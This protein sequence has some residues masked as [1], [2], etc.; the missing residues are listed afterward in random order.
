MSN[1]D[2]KALTRSNRRL[3]GICAGVVVGMF[4]FGYALVPLY[5]VFCEITGL[6]GKT[7]VVAEASVPA[8]EVD[9]SR[10]VTV[11][12]TG[13]TMAG[14]P[15]EFRPVTRRMTVHPGAIMETSYIA[16]NPAGIAVAGQAVPS[17]APSVAA[18]HFNKTECFC[19]TRQVLQPGEERD[20]PVRFVV[21]PR[22]PQ[23][24]TTVTLSYSFFYTDDQG[25]PEDLSGQD[26][27]AEPES[28]VAA[29]QRG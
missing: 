16:R 23:D 28:Y 13:T 6:N 26:E 8:G 14:L 9:Y 1:D 27:P 18:A 24:V 17:V 15:W 29:A 22:L 21:D 25:S 10:T 12:F 19:F 4:A 2:K 11:E 3:V 5:E 20:M 7:G